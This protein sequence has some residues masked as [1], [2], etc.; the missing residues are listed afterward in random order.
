M[1]L[2]LPTSLEIIGRSAFKHT[3][4][5]N[6]E[7]PSSMQY[8]DEYAFN[9]CNNLE[10]VSIHSNSVH[11]GIGVFSDCPNLDRIE[12]SSSSIPDGVFSGWEKLL[13]IE[14]N[15][16]YYFQGDDKNNVK[17]MTLNFG[18]RICEN[19]SSLCTNLASVKISSSIEYIESNAFY[20]CYNLEIIEMPSSLTYIGNQAFF[21]CSMLSITTILESV[22]Y[23]GDSA[24]SGCSISDSITI[25]SSNISLGQEVFPTN[26]RAKYPNV[27]NKL[28]S[29]AFSGSDVTELDLSNYISLGSYACYKCEQLREVTLSPLVK[30]LPPYCFFGCHSLYSINI[31][32]IISF[33]DYS[34]FRV[35]IVNPV[36]NKNNK[37][38]GK[39]A[40]CG[41]NSI[42]YIDLSSTDSEIGEFCLSDC[43]N[44]KTIKFPYNLKEIPVGVA[45]CCINLKE[46]TIYDSVEIIGNAAFHNS[47]LLEINLPKYLTNIGERAFSYTNI[48]SI[49][50]PNRVHVLKRETFRQSKLEYIELNLNIR[51]IER[52]CFSGCRL[53]NFTI[54]YNCFVD[55]YAFESG[56]IKD[57]YLCSGCIISSYAFSNC[58]ISKITIEPNANLDK[59]FNKFKHYSLSYVNDIFSIDFFYCGSKDIS[60]E[61]LCNVINNNAKSITTN[62]RYS[63]DTLCSI[64][65]SN[66][67]SG[68]CIVRVVD[69]TVLSERSEISFYFAFLFNLIFQL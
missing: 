27:G 50:I 29:G 59:A 2:S 38:I 53:Q 17:T 21:G 57:V 47:S 16:L 20:G 67:T 66:K 12:F 3:H 9:S 32:N 33:G 30:E 39:A 55:E 25:L 11:L 68:F 65:A 60:D 41:C 34:L 13:K 35:K 54:P 45:Y 63:E 6:L 24:F 4:I 26:V 44:L 10:F 28:P 48:R 42:E 51:R 46:V 56:T 15:S 61:N 5:T 19:F 37:Y 18:S 69:R 22:N 7:I 64:K 43:Y 40:F 23:I 36:I 14:D 49:K 31:E 52:L 58:E 1:S 8:I 62:L